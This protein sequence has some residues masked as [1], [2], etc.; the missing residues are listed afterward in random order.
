MAVRI[1]IKEQERER[2]EKEDIARNNIHI[3]VNSP[4]FSS[5][6]LIL[7]FFSFL[8]S[9]PILFIIVKIFTKEGKETSAVIQ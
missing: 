7:Q 9:S 3:M 1:F 5:F 2:E 6:F 4:S 8:T